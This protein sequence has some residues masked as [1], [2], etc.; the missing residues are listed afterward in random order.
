MNV[1]AYKRDSAARRACPRPPWVAPRDATATSDYGL[2]LLQR[3]NRRMTAS[4]VGANLVG[5]LAIT[6]FVFF[7]AGP[8]LLHQ[9]LSRRL[10]NLAIVAAYASFSVV[11][12]THWSRRRAAPIADWVRSGAAPTAAVQRAV[13][14]A[15]LRQLV[16]NALIWL[17]AVVLFT[18]VNVQWSW[19]VAFTTGVSVLLGGVVT[20]TLAY[21]LSERVLRDMTAY[22]LAGSE[23]PLSLE[24][25]VTTRMVLSGLLGAGVPFLGLILIA[26]HVLVDQTIPPD[27]LAAVVLVLAVAGLVVG[28]AALYLAARSIA[29]PLN[30]MRGAV[31]RVRAGDTGASVDVYDSSE[32]GLLQAGF[33]HMVEGL[34]EREQLED[35]F[36][37]QV[38]VEVARSALARGVELGGETRDVAVLFIDI[39]GSTRLAVTHSP[40]EVVE[41]LNRFFSIVIDVVS[42]HGGWVNKF[43][44]DAALCVFGAPVED[45]DGRDHALAAAR[46]LSARL[47][48]ELPDVEAGIGVA[49]GE[50]VAGNVG[51]AERFEYTVIGDPV[52]EAAR[53][54]E[55]AKERGTALAS[56][57]MLA[58]VSP[59]E[60]RC[61]TA[62]GAVTLRGRSSP[63]ELAV[64]ASGSP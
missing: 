56:A 27:R 1:A 20:C 63:T 57:A 55:L 2:E 13:L 52:N 42:A 33:N 37:R 21:L 36:G 11:V 15:P 30:A 8:L 22:V 48:A 31:T 45:P 34:R 59:E 12:G 50:A 62:D 38:G 46:A 49:A 25:G 32:V 61:W 14:K 58:E 5:G 54:S 19:R 6:A 9:P 60:A 4:M 53:L 64:P 51:A 18:A 26:T 24:P 16:V 29:D 28:F 10:V 47:S 39:V 44:G 35:L 17:G 7:L 43:E 40:E 3:G 23:P 41:L